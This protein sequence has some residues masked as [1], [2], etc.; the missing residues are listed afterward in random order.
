[1]RLIEKILL[2]SRNIIP[3]CSII[4][5]IAVGI[6]IVVGFLEIVGSLFTINDYL[7]GK[8]DLLTLRNEVLLKIIGAV[9]IF[10]ISTI[11]ILFATGLYSLFIHNPKFSALLRESPA[12]GVKN[13]DELKNKIAKVVIMV[14]ILTFFRSAVYMKYTNS[15]D[16]FYLGLGVLALGI[17]I[18][19]THKS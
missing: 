17:A 9:D 3:F 4:T 13:L 11:L 2:W 18:F 8:I 16:L 6:L 19:I 10:L 14:L 5:L 12:L 1:M 7:S 15:L